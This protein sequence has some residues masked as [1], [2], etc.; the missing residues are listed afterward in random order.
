MRPSTSAISLTVL[1]S[2]A[3]S[4]LHRLGALEVDQPTLTACYREAGRTLWETFPTRKVS[5][6]FVFF[7]RNSNGLASVTNTKIRLGRAQAEQKEMK[8]FTVKLQYEP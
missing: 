5:I 8:C 6:P 3:F 4:R 2:P 7:S 1:F